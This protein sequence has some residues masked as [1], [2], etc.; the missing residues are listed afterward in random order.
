M[1][2]TMSGVC[3]LQMFSKETVPELL[4]FIVPCIAVS[5]SG[6]VNVVIFTSTR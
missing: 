1:M 6:I 4:W 3:V 5:A 2:M